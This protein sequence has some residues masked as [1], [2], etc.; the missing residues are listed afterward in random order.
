[1]QFLKKHTDSFILSF[2][3]VF[4]EVELK[5]KLKNE[6]QR[7]TLINNVSG[8]MHSNQITAIMGPSGSGKTSLLNYLTGIIDFP[9]SS[10]T[11][12]KLY[13]NSTEV[14]FENT[15]SYT[16]YVMQD[17][18]L[19]EILTPYECF[20]YAAR[21][22]KLVENNK[23]QDFVDCLLKDLQLYACK[24][25]IIG[26]HENK[27]VSG[28]ERKRTSIGVEL[29]SN[30]AIL[31]LDEPT[32]GLDSQT[33]LKIITLLR[34]IAS[35]KNMMIICT[36]HQP[37]SNI[38]NLFDKLMVLEKGSLI[39]TGLP[40]KINAY[41]EELG[42]PLSNLANP[43][44]SFMR[45]L[46][47]NNMGDTPTYFIDHYNHKIKLSIEMDINTMLE[48]KSSCYIDRKSMTSAGF[49]EATVVLSSRA[50]KN[51]FRNP[52]ML[53]IRFMYSLMFAF[54]CSSVFWQLEKTTVNGVNGRLGFF[55]DNSISTFMTH[56][57]AT[58]LS[59]PAERP[60]FIREYSAKMYTCSSYFLSKNL[61]ETPLVCLI[62][63]T[64]LIIIYFTVGLR[65][66]SGSHVFIF[67]GAYLLQALCAQSLGY[68]IGCFFQSIN[69][70][71]TGINV[72]ILPFTM[73]AGSII[74]EDSMPRWLFW[75]KYFSPMKYATEIGNRNEFEGNNEISLKNETITSDQIIATMN[76]EVGLTNCFVILASMVIIYR[77]IGF[78]LL[79]RMIKKTG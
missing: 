53:K 49:C 31:L 36:I 44:D 3:D 54:V 76:Y 59:F 39:Y 64:Y 21:L 42:R 38:F 63:L 9:Q 29:I 57:F 74:N 78:I 15:S 13:F 14:Q 11:G 50:L 16:G 52:A 4:Y 22:R 75:V 48:K 58:I 17:D 79:K 62:T 40:S 34:K 5:D 47:E 10:T 24:D 68:F 60:V 23:T 69:S 66:D 65:L 77:I 12:G 26:N 1:M 72:L 51:V 8:Y 27:G 56:I 67:Y 70:A 30:P 19:W 18:C 41:F 61:V 2:Q 55:F 37:S 73:F 25:T 46:V 43:A 7:K 45:T 35:E 32:S 20:Y 71:T 6:R 28:G 33:S